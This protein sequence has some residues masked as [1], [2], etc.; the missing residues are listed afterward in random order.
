MYKGAYMFNVS[1]LILF[2]GP[3]YK[4]NNQKRRFP[5]LGSPSNYTNVTKKYFSTFSYWV[6]ELSSMVGL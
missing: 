2:N 4:M 6:Y 3:R 1:G 5:C